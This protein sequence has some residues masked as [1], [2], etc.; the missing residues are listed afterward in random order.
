MKL[1]I[2]NLT[3]K[4]SM[5]LIIVV[6]VTFNLIIG[7]N[8]KALRVLP[9]GIFTGLFFLL[10]F[11]KKV[12]YKEKIIKSKIDI[13][14]TI[15][16]ITLAFPLI[17]NTYCSMQGT[18]EFIIK[19]FFVY[20][21]YLLVRNVVDSYKKASILIAT[22]VFSSLIIIVLGIDLLHGQYFKWLLEIL[23][24]WYGTDYRITS[25]FG[26]A[27]A[28]SIYIAFCAFLSIN[29]IENSKKTIVKILYG[30]YIVLATYIIY[31][32]YSRLVLILYI[33]LLIIYFSAKIINKIKHNKKLLIGLATSVIGL[34]LLFVLYIVIAMQIPG[35]YTVKTPV[36]FNKEFQPN[37]EYVFTFDFDII[38]DEHDDSNPQFI[39][40]EV[41]KYFKETEI[42]RMPLSR[43]KNIHQIKIKTSE[44]IY[45]IQFEILNNYNKKIVINSCYINGEEYY[46]TY[47]YIPHTISRVINSLSLKEKSIVQRLQFYENCLRIA[48]DSPIIGHGGNTWK[49]LSMAYED[50]TYAVKET[51]SYFFELSIS[52][53]IVGVIAFTSI[54]V[55][56]GIY[57]IKQSRE[58]KKQYLSIFVGLAMLIIYNFVFDFGMSFVVI[59]LTAFLYIAILQIE[60]KEELKTEILE[61]ISL[62]MIGTVVV[63]LLGA[64]LAK[65]VV[66][67]SSIKCNLSY[68]NAEYK[69][70][71]IKDKEKN[72]LE[73]IKSFITEEP[74]YAQNYVYELYWNA[75][76]ENYTKYTEEELYR[77]ID[78]GIETFKTIRCVSPV[79]FSTIFERANVMAEVI[80]KLEQ[81]E[82]IEKGKIDQVKEIMTQEYYTNKEFMLDDSRNNQSKSECEKSIRD[83]K[84]ILKAVNII[85]D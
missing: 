16:M 70:N 26:Y 4:V 77:Y 38:S 40:Y 44:D 12:F 42:A 1:K 51:H 69:F 66:N 23:D 24:L 3:N 56:V 57:F 28:V 64:N 5:L 7:G 30:I 10:L 20:S 21:M 76:F 45:Y 2:Y 61:Y 81:I 19:Y 32:S 43:T 35:P 17:F 36:K 55:L 33:A 11:T 59:I 79:Y 65:Y 82:A 14:V 50:D 48:K 6:I 83:Y 41:N 63:I 62:L 71:E 13:A 39:M 15:F 67:D 85:V 29:Q 60:R 22:T 31:I 34:L 68:Y 46:C 54:L 80:K 9:I 73:K 74:Y 84:N 78:F 53:G 37:T 25:T 75:I 72:N 8:E 27:N 52:Y 58:I 18:V 47:K 49:K